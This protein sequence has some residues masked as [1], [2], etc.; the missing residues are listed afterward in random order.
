M[1]LLL[2]APSKAHDESAVIGD[3]SVENVAATPARAGETSRITFCVENGG[4]Q[5]V[6]VTGVR[7]P[8]GEPTRVIGF[9]GRPAHTGEIGGFRVGPGETGKFDGKKVWI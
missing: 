6:T 4:S 5:G 1:L 9:L 2:P 7:L 3:V 8:T